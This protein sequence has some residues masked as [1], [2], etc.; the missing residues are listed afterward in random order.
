MG[1]IAIKL[2]N[3]F[4]MQIMGERKSFAIAPSSV[5]LRVY[6]SVGGSRSSKCCAIRIAVIMPNLFV[7]LVAKLVCM[8]FS[9][10]RHQLR[11]MDLI[12]RRFF[13]SINEHRHVL[14]HKLYEPLAFR[15]VFMFHSQQFQ[16]PH[17]NGI[18][19]AR[20]SMICE[21]LSR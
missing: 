10:R 21:R 12:F 14:A 1:F 16:W 17:E 20:K 7:D 5:A 2:A 8:G 19:G 9:V 13:Q 6:L 3:L 11:L 15:N 18:F 4:P